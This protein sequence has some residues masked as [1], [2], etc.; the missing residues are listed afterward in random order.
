MLA[1]EHVS[2]HSCANLR[3]H[4]LESDPLHAF[5]AHGLRSVA[6]QAKPWLH[7]T[8]R[9]P[10]PLPWSARRKAAGRGG[11]LAL[12]LPGLRELEAAP[13]SPGFAPPRRARRPRGGGGQEGAP[14]PATFTSKLSSVRFI[15]G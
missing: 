5:P 15:E 10:A 4:R 2:C 13:F 1:K 11:G 9:F 7:Y 12:T 6:L 3:A 8:Q 14:P